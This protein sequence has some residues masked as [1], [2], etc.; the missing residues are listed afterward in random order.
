MT[1]MCYRTTTLLHCTSSLTITCY[2]T[3]LLLLLLLLQ[4]ERLPYILGNLLAVALV[5]LAVGLYYAP[6]GG[7][8][9]M[10]R[11]APLVEG[12]S[13]KAGEYINTCTGVLAPVM[14]WYVILI[15]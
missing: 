2:R 15:L 7:A 9:L 8:R 5:A 13:L 4:S 10:R 14:K 12:D 1:T 6:A 11:D 3:L